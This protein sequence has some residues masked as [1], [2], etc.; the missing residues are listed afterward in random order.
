MTLCKQ[1]H[2]NQQQTR[3]TAG[4]RC[5][6]QAPTVQPDNTLRDLRQRSDPVLGHIGQM[7][8]DERGTELF[9][10]AHTGVHF[11]SSASR[12]ARESL[13]EHGAFPDWVFGL[14]FTR[15]RY[16]VFGWANDTQMPPESLPGH[17]VEHYVDEVALFCHDWG[18]IYPAVDTEKFRAALPPVLARVDQHQEL[19]ESECCVLFQLCS[20]LA[21]NTVTHDARQENLR[22]YDTILSS[23]FPRICEAG[24]LESLLALLLYTLVLQIEG[25]SQLAVQTNGI[26][27]RLAQSLGLHRH[28]RRFK[29][30]PSEVER[31]RRLWWCVFICDTWVLRLLV[32]T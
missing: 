12:Q 23:I 26:V 24:N 25:R 29:L 2:Q 10:G 7:V 8:P 4:S 22:V 21:I 6:Q 30:Q 5:E 31:R 32:H 27:V 9:L 3:A 15:Q 17:D 1:Q 16:P 11:L 14:F 13:G 18:G 20:I 19:S 28:S